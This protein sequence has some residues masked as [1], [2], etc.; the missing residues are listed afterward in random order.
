[1]EIVFD[2]FDDQSKSLFALFLS[3][4]RP[5]TNEWTKS[6]THFVNITRHYSLRPHHYRSI[7]QLLGR[8]QHLILHHYHVKEALVRC[9]TFLQAFYPVLPKVKG[10]K[11]VLP[12]RHLHKISFHSCYIT[13]SL[14]LRIKDTSSIGASACRSILP[15]KRKRRQRYFWNALIQQGRPL[16]F[17]VDVELRLRIL[18]FLQ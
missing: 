8:K 14:Q 16:H 15:D 7:R 11:L 9:S 18:L 17:T 2:L 13:H 1:M 12:G 3:K 5:F 4:R 6:A 10:Q